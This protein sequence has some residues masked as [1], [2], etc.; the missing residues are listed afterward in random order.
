MS[1][2]PFLSTCICI[3]IYV[4][5]PASKQAFDDVGWV[6]GSHARNAIS[7]M[8]IG[9][10]IEATPRKQKMETYVHI[11]IYTC[12]LHIYTYIYIVYE[13][14]HRYIYIHTETDRY[15]AVC[16]RSRR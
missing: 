10:T 8:A 1:I 16:A 6:A 3:H 4:R 14:I 7:A 9:I 15:M 2:Y 13:Y 5:T 12:V 11:Y